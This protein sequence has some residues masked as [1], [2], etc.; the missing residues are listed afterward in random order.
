MS[1]YRTSSRI[2]N[3]TSQRWKVEGGFYTNSHMALCSSLLSKVLHGA[4]DTVGYDV[5]I[6]IEPRS[7]DSCD[8]PK[9]RKKSFGGL[10]LKTNES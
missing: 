1:H 2:Q 10:Q 3:L 6:G 7:T 4:Q 8:A 9:Q 5:T